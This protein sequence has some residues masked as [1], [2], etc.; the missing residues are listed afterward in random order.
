MSTDDQPTGEAMPEEKTPRDNGLRS[1]PQ[2]SA[3]SRTRIAWALRSFWT[4]ST[5]EQAEAFLRLVRTLADP[6]VEEAPAE[7][8]A[9]ERAEALQDIGRVAVHLALREG[10]V[11]TQ[12][13]YEAHLDALGLR[14]RAT[15]VAELWN[16][17]FRQATMHWSG[18][19]VY[20]NE[21][22]REIMVQTR[23]TARKNP[24]DR[25]EWALASIR[26]WLHTNPAKRTVRA[27]ARWCQRATTAPA[28]CCFHSLYEI[29]EVGFPVAVRV[30]DGQIT[31]AEARERQHAQS[32]NSRLAP[33]VGARE[34]TRI[35]GISRGQY[36]YR[37]KH[38]S[39]PP[40]M[41]FSRGQTWLREDIEAIRDG[42]SV[43]VRHHEAVRRE[44]FD[45]RELA[46]LLGCARKSIYD[47]VSLQRWHLVPPPTQ[48]S[49]TLYAWRRDEVEAWLGRPSQ[50]RE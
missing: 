14:H 8:L 44:W 6:Q 5:P 24:V 33:L 17:R 2:L 43:P 46:E 15:K 48:H 25:D 50:K 32:G 37:Q 38:G 26:A 11:P 49:T 16:G 40:A 4:L 27:Y 30:A 22:T 21:R 23:R 18:R 45:V 36:Q 28:P 31:L 41:D 19:G 47:R 34:V 29:L 7:R 13:Q 20:V 1:A 10:Q 42:Q 3:G 9:R 35:L 12:G 39:L